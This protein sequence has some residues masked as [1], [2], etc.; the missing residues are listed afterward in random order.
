MSVHPQEGVTRQRNFVWEPESL[1]VVWE[2]IFLHCPHSRATGNLLDRLD[3]CHSV[4]CRFSLKLVFD[5]Y[6]EN[7]PNMAC[8]WCAAVLNFFILS[9]S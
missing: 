3:P 9:S 2:R 4:P 5:S 6:E 1:T 7:Y 8:V